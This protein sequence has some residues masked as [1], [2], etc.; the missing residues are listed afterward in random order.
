MREYNHGVRL[1]RLVVALVTIGSALGITGPV[2]AATP[3]SPETIHTCP[4]RAGE[5][6]LAGPQ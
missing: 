6:A 4:H 3:T 1:G 2:A 5:Q